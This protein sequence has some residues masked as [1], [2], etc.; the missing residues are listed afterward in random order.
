MKYGWQS[1]YRWI[2]MPLI[3][4][5]SSIDSA[6]LM[7]R[8]WIWLTFRDSSRDPRECNAL[9]ISF[10]FYFY[11]TMHF[12][13]WL[14]WDACWRNLQSLY[15]ISKGHFILCRSRYIKKNFFFNSKFACIHSFLTLF[16]LCVQDRN[17]PF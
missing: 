17:C 2:I 10:L 14:R 15:P 16:R 5:I 9:K 6:D 12:S 1:L 3:F 4:H 7:Q 8:E 13:S 11:L